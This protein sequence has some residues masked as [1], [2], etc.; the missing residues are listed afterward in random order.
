MQARQH[1]L[2]P[3]PRQWSTDSG[4]S[5]KHGQQQNGPT[6]R[7]VP[8]VKPKARSKLPVSLPT[9]SPYVARA[10][11]SVVSGHCGGL[12]AP[13]GGERSNSQLGRCLSLH[14]AGL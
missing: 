8:A 13:S 14:T 2:S 4:P 10:K 12:A 1:G 5:V 7:G 11:L 3:V 9:E 6:Q